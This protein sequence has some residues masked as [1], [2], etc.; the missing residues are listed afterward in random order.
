MAGPANSVIQVVDAK[1]RIMIPAKYRPVLMPECRIYLDDSNCLAL[2]TLDHWKRI[3]D[4][5][6]DQ[7]SLHPENDIVAAAVDRT[8]HF[9]ER[10]RIDGSTGRFVLPAILRSKTD[11][12]PHCEAVFVRR[13]DRI[14]IMSRSR[15]D[16]EFEKPLATE[17]VLRQQKEILRSVD[18]MEGVY[19]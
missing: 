12:E 13:L 15:Y 5:M 2:V 1:W 9:S 16:L 18:R 17:E 10:V 14:S 7:R 8:L 19:E 6:S 4:R 3:I 11:L